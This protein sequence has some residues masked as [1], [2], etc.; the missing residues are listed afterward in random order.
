[1][2]EKCAIILL[3]FKRKLVGLGYYVLIFCLFVTVY[4]HCHHMS[5]YYT[6]WIMLTV[7]LSNRI[8]EFEKLD[9]Y[10]L[11]PEHWQ[12]VNL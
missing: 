5:C 9:S 12:F 7:A 10:A 11:T 4:T 6:S 8:F 2:L 1:M 3:I